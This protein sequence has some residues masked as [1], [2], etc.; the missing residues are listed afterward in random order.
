MCVKRLLII[1]LLF[2]VACKPPTPAEQM[3]SVLSWLGTAEMAGEAWLRHT[4]PDK[5][6]RQTLEHSNEALRPIADDL[7]KAP[8]RGIDT[9]SL[10]GPL[11]RSQSHIARMAR[12]VRERN[13]PAFSS[14]LDSLRADRDVVKQVAD[15]IESKQ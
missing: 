4:T 12:L 6:T 8:P 7:L 15:A 2:S 14:Q 11:A 9:A 10:D 5:Y 1:P 3:D 13:A